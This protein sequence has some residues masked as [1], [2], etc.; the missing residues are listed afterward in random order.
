MTSLTEEQRLRIAENKRRAQE[1]F[2]ERNQRINL[3]LSNVTISPIPKRPNLNQYVGCIPQNLPKNVLPST[4]NFK[5]FDPLKDYKA[6]VKVKLELI[7]PTHV[8]V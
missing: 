6:K 8:E 1:R 7:S 2:A 4:S 3:N 5:I